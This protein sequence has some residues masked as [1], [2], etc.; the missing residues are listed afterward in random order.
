M[1]QSD[2]DDREENQLNKGDKEIH[3]IQFVHTIR[4]TVHTNTNAKLKFLSF[5]FQSILNDKMK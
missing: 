1:S 5:P 2:T 3:Y 4:S